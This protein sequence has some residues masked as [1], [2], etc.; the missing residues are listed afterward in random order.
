VPTGGEGRQTIKDFDYNGI[1]RF[2]EATAYVTGSQDGDVFNTL[3]T[4]SI[5]G[6]NV[7]NVLHVDYLV[8]SITSRHEKGEDEGEITFQG[9]TVDNLRI[10]GRRIEPRFNH[11]FYARYAKHETLMTA[12]KEN[13]G[14]SACPEVKSWVEEEVAK[15]KAAG[16]AKFDAA[17]EK[18]LR[19]ELAGRDVAGLLAKRFCWNA[20][21]TALEGPQHQS[22]H[23][24]LADDIPGVEE[25]SEEAE[26]DMGSEV[27]RQHHPIRRNGY[28]VTV[29]G[30]GK[31]RLAEVVIKPGER[32]FNM[33][34]FQFGC[35]TTGDMTVGSATTNGTELVP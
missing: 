20:K 16:G 17:E 21:T 25:V 33:F 26:T 24:S 13:V 23:A 8:A 9:T 7:L 34:R 15:A 30:F 11:G 19:S 22:I 6:L 3:S 18:K 31:I 28:I 14:T 2:A 1:I 35:P 10:G 12:L 5:S 32:R 29:A 4:I 27:L